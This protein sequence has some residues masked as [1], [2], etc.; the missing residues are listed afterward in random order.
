MYTS[1]EIELLENLGVDTSDVSFLDELFDEGYDEGYIDITYEM[2]KRIIQDSDITSLLEQ[3][4]TNG[5]TV[6]PGI[7]ARISYMTSIDLKEFYTSEECKADTFCSYI[8]GNVDSVIES[9]LRGDD[10]F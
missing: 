4:Y 5:E 9:Y 1:K 8:H 10:D 3:C 2:L 7:I 6:N